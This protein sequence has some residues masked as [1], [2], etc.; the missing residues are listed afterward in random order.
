FMWGASPNST[1]HNR[2][3]QFGDRSLITQLA[4]KEPS[5]ANWVIRDLSPNCF[6]DYYRRLKLTSMFSETSTAT[7]FFVPGLTRHCFSAGIAFSSRQNPRL[8][9]TR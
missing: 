9:T 5:N 6:C 4:T 3:K 7:P 2:Q 1:Y 8:R